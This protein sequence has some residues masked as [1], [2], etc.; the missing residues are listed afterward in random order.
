MNAPI[1]AVSDAEAPTE[2][3]SVEVC[4]ALSA[5]ATA[6][7]TVRCQ[8]VCLKTPASVGDAV[9][10]LKDPD[11]VEALLKGRLRAAVFGQACGAERLLEA[12]DRIELLGPVLADPKE[13]RV[14]RAQ[15]QR[16][17][18]GDRRWRV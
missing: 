8:L 4:W 16:A 12:G 1:K 18:K 5:D 3:V 6:C 14:R 7:M 11:L 13:A 15:V 2:R 17:R 10:A 9:A